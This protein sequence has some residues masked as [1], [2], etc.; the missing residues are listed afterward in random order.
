MNNRYNIRTFLILLL[1]VCSAAFADLAPPATGATQVFNVFG[2]GF[3]QGYYQISATLQGQ[4]D[5]TY[6]F[7]EDARINDIDINVND[8]NM[9][10]LATES[11]VMFT[12]DGGLTWT[13]LN[14]ETDLL[15]E[16][17]RSGGA[18]A[19]IQHRSTVESI[20][21]YADDDWVAGVGLGH[22]DLGDMV[23]HPPFRSKNSGV[24]WS[25]A[26]SGCP[27]YTYE[28]VNDETV[29]RATVWEMVNEPTDE[30][31]FFGAS[32]S[33]VLSFEK[34]KWATWPGAG[35]PQI[36]AEWD[37]LPVYDIIYDTTNQVMTAAT[38][39]GLYEGTV[40][41][42][43]EQVSWRPLGTG[44]VSVLGVST[45]ID[46][47]YDEY[48]HIDSTLTSLTFSES[49]EVDELEDG[50]FSI[51]IDGTIYLTDFYEIDTS[52]I[53]LIDTIV[54]LMDSLVA[55][56]VSPRVALDGTDVLTP[57]Q[58]VN[59][60]DAGS[61]LFWT[62]KARFSNN[63]WYVDLNTD[64]QYFIDFALL[65]PD[66]IDYTSWL[67]TQ[68][69]ITVYPGGSVSFSTLASDGSTIYAGSDHGIYV[70]D[71]TTISLDESTSGLIVN[72][73]LYANDMILAG[74]QTG[75]YQLNGG[76]WNMVSPL[77]SDGYSGDDHEFDVNVRS[78]AVDSAGNIYFGGQMGGLFKSADNGATWITL[79]TGLTHREV[80]LDQVQSYSDSMTT[81]VFSGLVSNLGEFSDVDGDPKIY[82]LLMDIDDLYYNTAGD[83]TTYFKGEILPADLSV[84]GDT[85]A[86]PNSNYREII[87]VDVNPKPVGDPLVLESAAFQLGLLIMQNADADE[88]EWV[89]NGM[90]G[91]G[92]YLV[93]FKDGSVPLSVVSNNS[94]T[95]WSDALP[96][97]RDYEHTF[98]FMDY[99]YENYFTTPELLRSFV[100]DSG[101]GLTGLQ[102]ALTGAGLTTT[103]DDVLK[104]FSLAVFFDDLVDGTGAL[105]G[106][107][108]WNFN[109]LNITNSAGQLDWG[110][111]GGDSP[112][113]FQ[114]LEN[115]A[116]FFYS[117]GLSGGVYWAPGLGDQLIFNVDD[118]STARVFVIMHGDATNDT[119]PDYYVEEVSLDDRN[120]GLALADLD[121]FDREIQVDDTTTVQTPGTYN[122][123]NLMVLTYDAGTVNGGA[124][125]IH[126]LEADPEMLALGVSQ[127]T[128]LSEY[129]DIYGFGD[130]R[131]FDDGGMAQFYNLDDD[132]APEIEGPVA[133]VTDADG[134]TLLNQTLPHFHIDDALGIFGYRTSLALPSTEEVASYDVSLSG[135][136]LWGNRI[137]SDAL[138]VA[139][140]M[141]SPGNETMLSSSDENAL[142]RIGRQ[143]LIESSM[144]TMISNTELP[145]F[146]HQDYQ[147]VEDPDAL[148]D[149]VQIGPSNIS[150]NE[151]VS[152]TLSYTDENMG[153]EDHPQVFELIEGEWVPVPG[154]HNEALNEIRIETARFGSFQIRKASQED[155][156]ELPLNFALHGN[157]PNPFNPTTT[158]RYDLAD[159]SMTSLVIYNMLGQEVVTLVNSVQP[160]GM[161]SVT[162]NGESR[163]G[164]PVSSG[165]YLMRLNTDNG[166][167][168]HKMVYLK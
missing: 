123:V 127:S 102:N 91:L 34:R 149:L 57:N 166:S 121:L 70:Y 168:N 35:L 21:F 4:N 83:G 155:L 86:D 138:S 85:L 43:E 150:L 131:I 108:K 67:P 142:L 27:S 148:S 164:K 78:I 50:S 103:F 3:F 151:P 141:G 15:P 58:W 30:D 95:L 7:V 64:G 2:H 76:S 105:F 111:V 28:N 33:G 19:E 139:A 92:S 99:L 133:L 81:D 5:N 17:N 128:V 45:Y 153:L 8:D 10:L 89:N 47:S 48:D 74:T 55:V 73:M 159:Q 44:T 147:R 32:R 126:D 143:S 145:V 96:V 22:Y 51:D 135:E 160:A 60:T 62:G 41:I 12:A 39:L 6:I 68:G 79:N 20:Y 46:S 134:D 13:H 40:D 163:T 165:V 75:L 80:T 54:T 49:V 94:L 97:E 107:G 56:P 156:T 120:R 110:K 63:S 87:Y 132:P 53:V 38:S 125:V 29:D 130:S 98:V 16:G 158:I 24:K 104:D 100:A 88:D 122:V 23:A 129:I 25:P 26:G 114:A 71:G 167:F 31:N 113:S 93:G 161:Y 136:N 106:D 116:S 84:E 144:I 18:D 82:T 77:L 9:I 101:N 157:Y 154:F 118:G 140:V 69:D 119:L 66:S 115:S 14:G 124:F 59:V 137:T 42:E 146:L 36:T 61:G 109:N 11:G 152:L 90:A 162:W 65:D 112:Y 1:L 72:D 37:H 117:V 52:S